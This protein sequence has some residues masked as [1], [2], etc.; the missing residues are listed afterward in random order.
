MRDYIITILPQRLGITYL[1]ISLSIIGCGSKTL[2]KAKKTIGDKAKTVANTATKTVLAPSRPSATQ[3]E[4]TVS[5]AT[6]PFN[7]SNGKAEIAV[8]KDRPIAIA[9]MTTP[10]KAKGEF[11]KFFVHAHAPAANIEELVGKKLPCVIYFQEKPSK[12]LF[13]SLKETPAQLQIEAGDMLY[14]Q[15]VLDKT[16]LLDAA[17][18]ETITLSGKI[19]ALVPQPKPVPTEEEKAEAAAAKASKAK[20]KP[21]TPVKKEEEEK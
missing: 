5:S 10:D 18:E 9:L 3:I 17:G 8:L 19:T 21:K 2:E 1:F 13:Q 4:L 7:L 20:P 16:E 12:P 14:I 15:A 11:P 6:E